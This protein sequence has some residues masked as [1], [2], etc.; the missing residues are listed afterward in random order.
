MEDVLSR[1]IILHKWKSYS[2]RYK[3][4]S[5]TYCKTIG[6][7]HNCLSS[8]SKVLHREIVAG[9]KFMIIIMWTKR[10]VTEMKTKTQEGREAVISFGRYKNHCQ[11]RVFRIFLMEKIA[12]YFTLSYTSE[13]VTTELL[14]VRIK[15]E[16]LALKML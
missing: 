2:D 5:D 13:S 14:F 12:T 7:F 6:E 4:C 11:F 16:R 15:K 10:F 8:I 9:I 1:D 3:I